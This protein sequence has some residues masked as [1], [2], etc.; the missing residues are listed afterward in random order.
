[1]HPIRSRVTV[2]VLVLAAALGAACKKDKKESAGGAA[3]AAPA[4]DELKGMLAMIPVNSDGVLGLDLAKLRGSE[5]YKSYQKQVETLAA[6]GLD[7]V[8]QLCGFDPLPKI[9][10]LVV[11]GV[12]NQRTGDATAIVKGLDKAETLGCLQ[13]AAA[14]AQNDFKVTVD[15]DYAIVETLEKPGTDLVAAAQVD[16]GAAPAAPPTATPVVGESVSLQFTD[17]STVVIARR[18]GKAVD[19]AGLAAIIGGTAGDS[20]S[21]SPGFMEMIDA[22][23]TD[24]VIWFVI[25]GKADAVQKAGRGFLSF[26]AAFGHVQVTSALDVSVNLR[27]ESDAA[28]ERFAQMS[29]RQLDSMK[30]SLMKDMIGDAKV[31]QKGRDV[32]FTLHETREQLQKLVDFASTFLSGFLDQ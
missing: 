26:D 21:K 29:Q 9:Q 27:L 24:A 10:K 19:K 1:V 32:R 17:A 15:G 3:A 14:Q 13:K 16:A 22:V 5:L 23:D 6:E 28:A 25:N 12:G 18:G 7:Q 4:S 11:G 8:K 20:I 2:A 30:K 31:E